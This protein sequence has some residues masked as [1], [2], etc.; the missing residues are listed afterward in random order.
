MRVTIIAFCVLCAF[1]R[2]S[3]AQAAP[4]DFAA[5]FEQR[6]VFDPAQISEET[7][8]SLLQQRYAQA[9]DP[10]QQAKLAQ[11]ILM[12]KRMSLWNANFEMPPETVLAG[13][14]LPPYFRPS[15]NW[16]WSPP[17]PNPNTGQAA[18]LHDAPPVNGQSAHRALGVFPS[19]L[20]VNG[21]LLQEVYFP[22]DAP[23]SRVWLRITAMYAGNARNETNIVEAHWTK[24]AESPPRE[25]NRPE[26][27]WAG[28]L[29]QQRGWHTLAVN[30]VDF[31][32]CG[33]QR[34]ISDIEFGADGGDAW[35]GRTLIRRPP[36]EIRG[37]QKYHIFAPQDTLSFE[38]IAHNFS[39]SPQS[40]AVDVTVSDYAGSEI[41][42]A[43]YDFEIPARESQ[44]Q[45]LAFPAQ[46]RRYFIIEYAL[47]EGET[48]IF[49]GDSAA[50]IILP[51]ASGRDPRSPF[52]MMY[53]DQPGRDMAELYEKLGVKL[54]VI[55]P[56]LERL[57]LFD[58]KK[59]DVM[60]M[61]WTLPDG[62]P[63][64]AE[65]L[66]QQIQPYIQAGQRVFSNF[67]ETDLRVPAALFAAH[68]RRFSEVVKA[69]APDALT[70]IGGM[71]WFNVAYVRQLLQADSGRAPSFDFAAAMSYNTPTPPEYSG[72]DQEASALLALFKQHGVP[73]TE[74]WNVEWA[75]FEMLNVG[76]G[77]WQNTG[78]AQEQI[79]AYTIRHHL[80][81]LASGLTRLIPGTNIYAGRT[82]FFKNF[83]H[84][85]SEGR[86]SVLRYDLTPHPLL[87]AY[88][89]MTRL[90]EGA[91]FVKVL[92][93]GDPSVNCQIYRANAENSRRAV[94]AAWTA[95]GHEQATLRLPFLRDRAAAPVSVA[96]MLGE[97]RVH[98]ARGGALPLDLS[99]EP[100]YIL[101]PDMPADALDALE[102][103]FDAPLLTVEPA[104]IDAAPGATVK[105]TYHL[106]NS[107][108]AALQGR[109][110][111]TQP[112]W[113]EIV[114]TRAE[115]H[116]PLG[117]LLA[118][119]MGMADG[120]A[121]LGRGRGV[122]VTVEAN[123]PAGRW[124][125]AY[126]EQREAGLPTPLDITAEFAADGQI[127]ASATTS[128]RPRPP[129]SLRIR[130]VLDSAA[131]A[132]A[133][134]IEARIINHSPERRTGEVWL[135]P[136]GWMSVAPERQAFALE[137]GA[138]GAYRF[139]LTG[140]P[141][142]AQEYLRETVDAQLTRT[143][144][145]VR[146]TEGEALRLDHYKADSGY[147]V[148]FGVGEGYFLDAFLRDASGFEARQGRG[149]AFRPAV[150]AKTPIVV[151]GELND[152]SGAVPLFVNPAG[153]LNGL[154]FFA[155]DFGGE[156]QWTGNDDF[157]SAWEMLWD[158]DFLYVATRV[159]DDRVIPQQALGMLWNGDTVSLQI[160]PLADADASPAPIP[161][162]LRRAHTFDFGM[163]AD[164]PVLR[165]KY[166]TLTHPAGA[167]DAIKIAAK[168]TAD[169]MQYE[170]AIPWTELAPLRPSYAGWFGCSFAWYED[171]GNGRETFTSWFGG[172]GGN[173]L[174]REPRLMGDAHFVE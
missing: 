49:R 153:R 163:S 146:V 143:V 52:G 78:V 128:A 29:P 131:A 28:A 91:R 50:A 71:A 12:L 33:A 90:L 156:M 165:R 132:N 40:R 85:M 93:P 105:L 164:R 168:R 81:G 109:L 145:T 32:L 15:E 20:P 35:F 171:D 98:V 130:P 92:T 65:K 4:D 25:E 172:S 64:E 152:W 166:P 17:Q 46:N 151:D 36:V 161:G 41:F 72:I 139:T 60:P 140:M 147:L 66:R 110:A 142:N 144:Q 150:R 103:R 30:L 5:D 162:D 148:T 102:F 129:L 170:L 43:S 79:A 133:P 34:A 45:T 74:L 99:P 160:A 118:K 104:E 114:N 44:R 51:N 138:S 123:I 137:P 167:V 121:L 22:N 149:F 80:F 106:R 62:K 18:R 96:N 112:N 53:W 115:Y 6:G 67:W 89:T 31:G 88:A 141:E 21:T 87:P 10:A 159:F 1:A 84:S 134:V 97:E 13:D 94:I 24:D 11:R 100:Q 117:A 76:R 70:G 155:K 120:T 135:A 107:G 16:Q 14:P 101:L 174:A 38:I 169:G 23:P 19:L 58:A 95:F 77:E 69:A 26:N 111:V 7:L 9:A 42:R 82:P 127:L 157:S 63:E 83:G 75:Y 73:Q 37:A 86:A 108:D 2:L 126:A 116:D 122:D 173:G 136:S 125:A 124:R 57:R 68:L 61:I 27:F 54:L 59:F 8:L 119:N 158:D 113:L 39:P 47:R 3:W 55:F 154:T 56:E 48:T